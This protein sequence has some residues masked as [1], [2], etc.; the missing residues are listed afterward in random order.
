MSA[1]RPPPM[2]V[3]ASMGF[4]PRIRKG[5]F[6]W[7][8]WRHGCRNWGV[9]NRTYICSWFSDPV[10]EY[11]QVVKKVSLW[12]AMGERQVEVSGPDAFRLVQHLTPRD[13]TRCDI[14]QC[15]YA[16]ITAADG[17]ILCDPIILRLEEDRF[18]LSTSDC[19]L[20]MWVRGVAT[21]MGLDVVVRDAGVSV[22]QVQGP[23]SPHVMR[24]A[25]GDSV[26]DLRNFGMM[27]VPFQDTDL[28]VTR[29]GWSGEF[30]YE[31]YLADYHKGDALFDAL[32]DAGAPWDIKPGAVNHAK[33]IEAGLLSWGLDMT[34]EQ[35][36]YDLDLG[37]L[38]DL[39]GP[40]DFIGRAALEVA[41][42]Q[43]PRSTVAGLIIPGDPMMANQDVWPV[44]QGDQQIGNLTSLAHSPRR[45]EN[46]ALAVIEAGAADQGTTLQV[47]T[48][49]GKV[50]A[51]VSAVPFMPK[52]QAGNAWD[53]VA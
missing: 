45:R 53:L 44:L 49:D 23:K 42:K 3:G 36:P 52:R 48:P 38:V 16:L 29:T 2:L 28:I 39:D 14:G 41:A 17:G 21:G 4:Q 7:A 31:V 30:G 1:N 12:P 32:M 35:T 10:S 24:A 15:R 13:M 27:T 11:W 18:W 26:L 6:H 19:D 47:F 22:L 9:Y 34:A 40:D 8:A 25:F 20:E 33:R 37:W 43:P 5:A 50:D 46:I 51:E